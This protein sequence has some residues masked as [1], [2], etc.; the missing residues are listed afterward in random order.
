MTQQTA[1]TPV[2]LHWASVCTW[3]G[4]CW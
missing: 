1:I 3:M 4:D 2:T